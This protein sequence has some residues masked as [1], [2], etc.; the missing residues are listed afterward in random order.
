MFPQLS[1]VKFLPYI[2]L[3][4]M[5]GG[6]YMYYKSSQNTIQELTTNNVVLEDSLRDSERTVD[7][8]LSNLKNTQEQITLLNEK[9]AAVEDNNAVLIKKLRIHDLTRLSLE[10]PGL[11]EK[12]VN[13]ATR[14][15]F[16]EIE[17]ITSASTS[18]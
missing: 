16:K 13:D 3:V 2:L 5:V 11:I 14:D 12:R 17:F 7:T 4:G 10:K 15:V 6:A 8:L 9:N 18:S 1:L